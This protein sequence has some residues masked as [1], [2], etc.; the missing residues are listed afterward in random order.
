VFV[1][2]LG[3]SV[4]D[5]TRDMAVLVA[6]YVAFLLV[7]LAALYWALYWRPALQ[8]RRTLRRQQKALLA[9]SGR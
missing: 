7:G 8:R 3:L 2:T 4:D 5:L 9:V 1:T 6:M